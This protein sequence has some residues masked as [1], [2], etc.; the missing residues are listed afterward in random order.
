MSDSSDA[1]HAPPW[2]LL[3]SST[4]AK[5][6]I[7]GQTRDVEGRWWWIRD[8]RPT[9]H[10][11]DLLCGSLISRTT[12]HPT[13][14]PGAIPTQP[15]ID[16]WDAN[17]RKRDCT[18]YDLPVGS[19]NLMYTRRRYGFEVHSATDI[20]Y[21]ERIDDLRTLAPSEFAA[22]HSVKAHIVY[23]M[24]ARYLGRIC[25]ELNWWR[26]SRVRNILLSRCSSSEKARKLGICRTH[27]RRLACQL[28]AEQLPIAS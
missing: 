15:L 10:G 25:R 11:F 26:G 8:V 24:R 6:P 1:P 2:P 19:T 4:R 20:F 16:F 9:K 12:P 14:F 23:K 17:S 13:G 5:Y 18:V 22:K 27:A 7:I 21:R 28:A 3:K